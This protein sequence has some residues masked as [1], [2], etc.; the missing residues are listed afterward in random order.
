MMNLE[1][2]KARLP[3][4][5]R[6]VRL[7]LSTV[8]GGTGTPGLTE[9]QA[10]GTALACAVAAKSRRWRKPSKRS[11]ATSWIRRGETRRGQ[12]RRSWR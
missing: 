9:S 10:L 7:N 4:Y 11:A 6:D 8:L 1:H 2:I 12:R 5:A 3:E